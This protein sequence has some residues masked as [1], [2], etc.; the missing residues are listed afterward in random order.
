MDVSLQIE[1]VHIQIK[2]KLQKDGVKLWLPPY[3]VEN[4]GSSK[5]DLKV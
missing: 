2:D 5:D 4:V 3:Y 1:D